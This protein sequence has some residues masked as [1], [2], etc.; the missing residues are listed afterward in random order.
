MGEKAGP[1]KGLGENEHICN[2]FPI[3]LYICFFLSPF[4]TRMVFKKINAHLIFLKVGPNR[5]HNSRKKGLYSK[6]PYFALRYEVL[7]HP[8]SFRVDRTSAFI[9]GEAPA[10]AAG[11]P[12][13]RGLCLPAWTSR[14][15]GAFLLT[16]LCFWEEKGSHVRKRCL[17]AIKPRVNFPGPALGCR[18]HSG[19][20]GSGSSGWHGEA[21]PR[22]RQVRAKLHQ[23]HVGARPLGCVLNSLCGCPESWARLFPGTQDE[24]QG[25]SVART[26]METQPTTCS[27]G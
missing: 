14:R 25:G 2:R 21:S 26:G 12:A 24:G 5:S 15:R 1:I 20:A 3:F 17:C 6:V 16:P 10:W 18:G 19:T 8:W 11:G 4:S 9:A 13:L 22:T 27:S 7:L 23:P